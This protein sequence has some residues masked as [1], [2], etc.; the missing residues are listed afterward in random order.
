[1]KRLTKVAGRM[2]FVLV[3]LVA[4]L[5]FGVTFIMAEKSGKG[6][7]G[8]TAENL[9]ADEKEEMNIGHGVRVVEVVKDEAADKA[10]IK[11]DDVILFINGEKIRRTSD[12]IDIIQERKA[13]DQITIKLQRDGK[14]QESKVT[15]GLIK[16]RKNDRED[17][18]T[19]QPHIPPMSH[20]FFR[21]RGAYL[22]ITMHEA[23]VDLAE[24][25]N[26]KVGE[27]VLI[28]TIEKGSPAEKA[29]LKAGDVIV[30]M[31]EMNIKNTGD[32]RSALAET[33]EKKEL[34]IIVIRHGKRMNMKADPIRNEHQKHGFIYGGDFDWIGGLGNEIG[35][36][37]VPDGAG[38]CI[39]DDL[40]IFLNNGKMPIEIA[41]KGFYKSQKGF[42]DLRREHLKQIGDQVEI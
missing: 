37:Q 28:L 20:M 26:F 31:G 24:Y 1:M 11:A 16:S 32:V 38:I 27:G 9:S 21:S 36:I 10:G 8:V 18:F 25:F 42:H 15:L 40:G 23:D 14:L 41:K 2:R 39:N 19:V 5:L 33:G 3:M 29:G 4:V 34:D 17:Y 22:G 12:L 7:L 30:Q 35:D 6:F 13:G